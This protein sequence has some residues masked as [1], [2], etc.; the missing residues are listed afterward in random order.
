MPLTKPQFLESA[1]TNM[2]AARDFLHNWRTDAREW[3]DFVAGKQ[4]ADEDEQ[5]L[6]EQKRPPIT[7]NYS[8]KMIDAVVGAEVANRNE[9]TYKPRQTDDFAAAE[10]W[11]EAARWARDQ[12]NAEF[13]ECDAFRDMLICGLGWTETKVSYDEDQD[14]KIDV[15][16]RD[17]LTVWY[18]PA[19]IK[20]GL[21]DRTFHFCEDW[22][23]EKDAKREWGTK[24]F[25]ATR[26][27][28]NA[29][30]GIIIQN[31]RYTKDEH[32]ADNHKGMVL[33]TCYECLVKE[34]VYRAAI[35]GKVQEIPEQDFRDMQEVMDEA[36]VIYVRQ[37]K[38]RYYRAY[39]SGD[40]LLEWGLS[41]CQDGFMFNCVT[42]KR[43]RNKN[44]WYGLTR[45]M[46]DPQRW[47][48]KWLSQI[49]HIINSNAKG[50]LMAETNAFVDIKK[51]Q[52]EWSSPDSITWLRE[53]ALSGNKVKERSVVNY[54]AGLDK[55]M[56]FA[57]GSLPMVT[58]INL[59]ALGL[60]NREQAGVLEA[61]R[62]QA[63]YGLL[64]PLFDALRLYRVQQ[65]RV[66][67][68]L[69]NEYIAD[70]RLI[71]IGGPDAEKFMP[72]AKQEGAL[73][74]DIVVD[75]SPNSPDVKER[76]WQA[77][78]NLV[79][80]LLKAGM[81][82]PP[83]V[84]D[85]A[86]IPTALATKWKEFAA[87][88]AQVMKPEEAQ[89]LQEENQKLKADHTA[90]MMKVQAE[91]QKMQAEVELKMKEVQ[92]MLQIKQLE[93]QSKIMIQQQQGQQKLV[94]DEQQHQQ[95]MALQQ[96]QG[97][98]SLEQQE[99]QGQQQT[100]LAERKIDNDHQVAMTKAR[101]KPAAKKATKRS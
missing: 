78:E 98:L 50:G 9:V 11:T 49:L 30:A 25:S 29:A 66:L 58:G 16:R 61:Q 85:F 43:D 18:D 65:G 67:L 90:E 20:S 40:T 84:L 76:T 17:P 93:S 54:P 45:V 2:R 72:L 8:E 89:K 94:Q 52:D 100:E 70:G 32:D 53:G 91:I 37:Y 97:E 92:A 68:G 13:E 71:R 36:Q 3:Y 86:P 22:V 55:L 81:A 23:Y 14:G 101:M 51:A 15:S 48:N 27:D 62:K 56:Q 31:Q 60:A 69:L 74:Y 6:R 38:N 35:G 12:C 34:P 88:N 73:K 47:A 19:A 46:M 59:E 95:Q 87:Q 24:M 26:E 39:F 44:T 42:G 64:S 1:L 77:L 10:L 33:I 4:W 83:D 75:Q 7:F 21:S 63:A 96:Q 28:P 5:K 57:L 80:A 82:V 41:P 99:Q 79:P